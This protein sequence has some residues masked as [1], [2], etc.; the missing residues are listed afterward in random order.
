MLGLSQT[1][2]LSPATSFEV[3]QRLQRSSA[4]REILEFLEPL[5]MLRMQQLSSKFYDR[6]I[7]K[8]LNT[9]LLS[10]HTRQAIY[11]YS[12]SEG[13]TLF[14]Y[15]ANLLKWDTIPY[16]H[17]IPNLKFKY[18]QQVVLTNMNRLFM[19]GGAEDENFDKLSSQM[20]EWDLVRNHLTL[21]S[22]LPK[23]LIDFGAVYAR[24]LIYCMKGFLSMNNF[25]KND[26]T[27]VYDVSRDVWTVQERLNTGQF[28]GIRCQGNFV[29][30]RYIYAFFQT[31]DV[32]GRIDIDKNLEEQI[33]DRLTVK[34]RG[35]PFLFW[36]CSFNIP[37]S[38]EIIMFGGEAEES[39]GNLPLEQIDAY[40]EHAKKVL[41]L[42]TSTNTMR[43]SKL[44]MPEDDF[45]YF[46]EATISNYKG[47]PT[48]FALGKDHIHVLS[49]DM[50]S[51]EVFEDEGDYG[52]G[53]G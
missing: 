24:G 45:F 8:T 7:P 44:R 40:P 41:I 26:D 38:D 46:N 37:G 39:S 3:H 52:Q 16:T 33:W 4:I 29:L 32:Y 49:C 12:V 11:S 2:S 31:M 13:K 25:A 6:V 48:V 1:S 10:H 28:P 51:M 20:L 53:A 36:I 22:P 21:R 19:L 50:S 42:N 18:S 5:E 27:Y 30:N 15:S 43:D 9:C 34:Q 35:T 14:K 23:A 17:Q 47:K